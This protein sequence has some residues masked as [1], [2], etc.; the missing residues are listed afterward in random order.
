MSEAPKYCVGFSGPVGAGKTRLT[1]EIIKYVE[2]TPSLRI[3]LVLCAEPTEAWS[4]MHAL[5]TFIADKQKW[6]LPFQQVAVASRCMMWDFYYK[7]AEEMAKQTDKYKAVLVLMERTYEDDDEF[8]AKEALRMGLMTQNQ[9][10]LY[11]ALWQGHRDRRPCDIN[12][13]VWVNTP[14]QLL[15]TRV[16]TRASEDSTR[17]CELDYPEDYLRAIYDK[18]CEVLSKG[19]FGGAKVM[20]I[21]G[22][23]PFH[24]DQNELRTI[25]DSILTVLIGSHCNG[26]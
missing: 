11:K 3:G 23:R 16:Q 17:A 19:T 20:E 5:E 6:A 14:F 21:D 1:T 18:H 25:L 13:V 24:T 7:K 26:K 15:R 12:L 22:A 2:A 8:F 9:Y 4:K 10:N